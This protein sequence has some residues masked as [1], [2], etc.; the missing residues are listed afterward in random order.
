LADL[1]SSKWG[2]SVPC[3]RP[4]AAALDAAETAAVARFGDRR[5]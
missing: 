2:N 5:M 1:I 4:H 3:F